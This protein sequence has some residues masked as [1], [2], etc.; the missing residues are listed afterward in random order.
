MLTEYTYPGGRILLEDDNPTT[1][2]KVA[3]EYEPRKVRWLQ[4]HLKP[5]MCFVDVGAHHGYYT[6]LAANLVGF[7]GFMLAFEPD[8]DNFKVLMKNKILNHYNQIW[9]SN[10]A[11]S[12]END[13]GKP[14]YRYNRSDQSSFYPPFDNASYVCIAT[15]YMFDTFIEQY[16]PFIIPDVIKI[17]TQGHE[18][19]VVQGMEQ[20]LKANPDCK[21]ILEV[22]PHLN[23][24][25]VKAVDLLKEWGIEIV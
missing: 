3:L 22:H 18:Y 12:H 20:T 19:Q 21:V 1:P 8:P 14:L 2:A 10:V 6:L 24:D 16:V 7:G 4:E 17:D 15:T 9:L 25:S 13:G 5:G 23:P 11:L